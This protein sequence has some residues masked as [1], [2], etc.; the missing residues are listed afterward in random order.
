[1]CPPGNQVQYENRD[2]PWQL[3]F[4]KQQPFSRRD[5]S[6]VERGRSGKEGV[7][8][9]KNSDCQRL[10][11]IIMREVGGIRLSLGCKRK[12]GHRY[13]PVWLLTGPR[14]MS[15][16]KMLATWRVSIVVGSFHYFGLHIIAHWRFLF[17]HWIRIEVSFLMRDRF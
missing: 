10:V 2:F 1:M 15:C 5:A 4:K 16:V 11:L 13:P 7:G 12:Q 14:G 17:S 3:V 8:I 9:G 6:Y